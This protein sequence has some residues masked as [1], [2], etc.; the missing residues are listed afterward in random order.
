[1][2]TDATHVTVLV[3]DQEAARSFWAETLGFE[4]RDDETV[5]EGTR[6]LTVAP[7]GS[8]G[9]ELTLVRADTD[10]KRARVGS[11]VADHVAVVFR[12]DDCRGDFERLTDRGVEFHGEPT[13]VPW[14]V[15]VTFEDPAGNVFDLLEPAGEWD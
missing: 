13:E 3:D 5:E 14:G 4:V 1:M 6:W 12:S 9:P 15:E 2:I 7:P 8:G 11:Q 10:E